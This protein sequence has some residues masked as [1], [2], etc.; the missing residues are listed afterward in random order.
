MGRAS[1]KSRLLQGRAHLRKHVPSVLPKDAMVGIGL[2]AQTTGGNPKGTLRDG[3]P[4]HERRPTTQDQEHTSK[5]H[6]SQQEQGALNAYLSG[7]G[8]GHACMF[9]ASCDALP[10][11]LS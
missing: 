5:A 6:S 11:G 10:A 3:K 1:T 4:A 8:V 9:S 7:G 2:A